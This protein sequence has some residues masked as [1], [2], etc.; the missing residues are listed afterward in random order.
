MKLVYYTITVLVLLIAILQVNPV[1]SSPVPSME[2]EHHHS[3]EPVKKPE[4]DNPKDLYEI[5]PQDRKETEQHFKNLVDEAEE[6]VATTGCCHCLNF[7]GSAPRRQPSRGPT[8]ETFHNMKLVHY[9]FTVLVLLIAIFHV[10]PV[11]GTPVPTLEDGHHSEESVNQPDTDLYQ[12][13]ADEDLYEVSPSEKEEAE[14]HFDNLAD[15]AEEKVVTGCC[16][17]GKTSS[18]TMKLVY[19]TFTVLVLAIALLQVNLVLGSPVPTESYA[20]DTESRKEPPPKEEEKEASR[21]SPLARDEDLYDCYPQNPDSRY[22]TEDL[23]LK[24]EARAGKVTTGSSYYK[25]ESLL[26]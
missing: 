22:A 25:Y 17:W 10:N 19:Y 2:D 8:K 9:T 23:L 12:P 1:S 24:Q 21:R 7:F 26:H 11:F 15:E 14:K 20:S 3:E 13:L 18:V 4:E 6:K 5:S 16:H